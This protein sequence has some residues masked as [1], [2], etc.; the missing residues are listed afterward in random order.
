MGAVAFKCL[1]LVSHL[2]MLKMTNVR[3]V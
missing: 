1:R 3:T 2:G